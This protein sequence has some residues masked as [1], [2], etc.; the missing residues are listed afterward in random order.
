MV[1]TDRIERAY[2]IV[3]AD[4][5]AARTADCHWEGELASSPLGTAVAVAALC[6]AADNV[7]QTQREDS[8][9]DTFDSRFGFD[10]PLI[11]RGV[12]YLLR[13]QHED[14]GWGDTDRDRSNISATIL[15]VAALRLCGMRNAEVR[16]AIERADA[17]IEACGNLEALRRRYGKDKTFVVP[18]L[19]TGA[20]AGMNEWHEVTAL[21]FELACLPHRWYRAVRLPVVSYAIPALV[22]MGICRD[23]HLRP[24][25]PLVRLIRR[26]LRR[27][28]I[29]IAQQM[30][31]D[32]GGFLE[33]TPLTGFVVM[34]LASSGW[35][36]HPVVERGLKF[37]RNSIREDGSWPIDTN[38]AVW[39]TTLSINALAGAGEPLPGEHVLRWLAACQH[40][41]EHPFTHARPGGWGWTDQSGAVPD[42]DD[43]PG[44]L[45]ALAAYWARRDEL[46]PELH[47]EIADAAVL[48]IRWLLELQNRDGGWPTFCKGWGKLP[49]DRSGVDLT[50]HVLRAMDA[51]L[52]IAESEQNAR[53][54]GLQPIRE[55]RRAILGAVR[56]G[57]RFLRQRQQPNGAWHPLWFGNEFVAGESNPVYGT[58][59]CLLAYCEWG[60]IASPEVELG[61]HWV[62]THQCRNGGWGAC[63]EDIIGGP[64]RFDHEERSEVA[65]VEETALALTALA[66]VGNPSDESVARSIERGVE[67]LCTAVESGAHRRAAAIGFYFAKLWYYEK[68]YPLVFAFEALAAVKKRYVQN[69]V[70]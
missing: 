67:W 3:L 8:G 33:A 31:P 62:T 41:E 2:K 59:K 17:Y 43:T 6:V 39:T 65:T 66:A 64:S 18:I 12:E 70:I 47:A 48:G 58:A 30:Q 9:S 63:R 61:V 50:A 69:E 36:M 24:R 34:A 10:G 32:S 46:P 23:V 54:T 26:R 68:M 14:G 1:S 13:T 37:L 15:A 21:P 56:R 60:K 4:L 11:R 55:A 19:T 40:R 38:L 42:A 25:N 5:M 27:K 51:W 45:L 20:L 35:R 44:A 57:F 28:A 53:V 49:F 16:A 22:A 52:R 29:D 7:R